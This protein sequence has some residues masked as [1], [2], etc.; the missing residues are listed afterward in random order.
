MRG[1]CRGRCADKKH[2]NFDDLSD[3]PHLEHEEAAEQEAGHEDT[4]T[5]EAGDTEQQEAAQEAVILNME[6]NK[7]V[8]SENV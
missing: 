5:G 1:Q 8:M 4:L 6:W 7:C 3:Q 2:Y